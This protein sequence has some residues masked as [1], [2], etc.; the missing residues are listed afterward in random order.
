MK[1]ALYS[2]LHLEMVLRPKGR[3]TWE[4]PAL[5]VD[6]V[7]LAGDIGS[8]T[9]GIEWAASAFRQCPVSPDIIYVAGNHEY[10]GAHLQEHT[11][12]MRKVAARLGVHFLE[13]GT[14]EIGRVRFLGTTLWSDFELYG[15]DGSAASIRAARSYI[16]DYSTIFAAGGK[17]IEPRDTIQLHR[18]ARAFLE[19]E[20]AKPFDD[21]TI[22]VTHFAPHRGCVEARFEG[23]TLT[24]YFTVDI[25][26]LM[27][28]HP[29]ALWA[30]GHTHY[31]V[32]FVDHG[33][34]VVSNQRGYPREQSEDFRD[35][36]VIE[37]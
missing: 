5:D 26:S 1:I 34:R 2:D 7:V 11:V 3:P 21:K 32:D 4:P 17:F 36:L 28:K 23:G 15:N 18:E 30:F 35:D 10:H 16:S 33:C 12:E 8:H 14:I 29:I 9:H 24:P 27:R 20:L 37:V 13:N 19:R 22:V 6:V 31:N 25:A